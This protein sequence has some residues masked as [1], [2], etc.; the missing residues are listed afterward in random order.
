MKKFGKYLFLTLIILALSIYLLGYIYKISVLKNLNERNKIVENVWK[1]Y[2]KNKNKKNEV[3]LSI[4]NSFEVENKLKDSILFY[5]TQKYKDE[6]LIYKSEEL[7]SFIVNE[8]YINKYLLI[9][10]K[11]I[12]FKNDE[13]KESELISLTKKCNFN[14]ETYNSTANDFNYYR[15][16]FPNFF[17]ANKRGF[18][19]LEFIDLMYG[20]ENKNP[21]E[22]S[23]I[24]KWIETGDE[25][26][27]E[28]EQK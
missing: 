15:S 24:D 1:D 16:V 21:N 13:I 23:N 18:K 3:F 11:N 8:Y 6:K 12:D 19:N 10:S 7:K 20:K 26:Y 5:V 9:L 4:I 14:I 17:I 28:K 25:K 27:L 22:K 2:I